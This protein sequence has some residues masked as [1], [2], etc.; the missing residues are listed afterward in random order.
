MHAAT[1]I[2]LKNGDW[3]AKVTAKVLS[4]EFLQVTTK[5]G[6]R[7]K[8]EVAKVVWQGADAAIV[9]TRS[10]DRGANKPR[11]AR[12]AWCN[13]GRGDDPM[14]T[15]LAQYAGQVIACPDCGG[16]IDVC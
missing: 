13:C 7:W 14:S 15:G 11:R 2:K 6:K 10:L 4:G 5:S 3:G 16:K 9:A 8:A 1:P 12:G